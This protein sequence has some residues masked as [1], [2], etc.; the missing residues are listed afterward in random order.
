MFD[1]IEPS[2]AELFREYLIFGIL[3]L[4]WA[5]LGLIGRVKRTK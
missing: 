4:F 5:L 1:L 2:K 3:P